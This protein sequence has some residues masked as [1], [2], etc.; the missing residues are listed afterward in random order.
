M[1]KFF[2]S[3]SVSKLDGHECAKTVIYFR[4]NTMNLEEWV[5][6]HALISCSIST[7]LKIKHC[8]GMTAVPCHLSDE[9]SEAVL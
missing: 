1:Y 5:L 7:A 4:K 6:Q 8:S 9:T 3:S 2:C